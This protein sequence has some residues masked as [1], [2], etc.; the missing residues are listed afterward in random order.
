M[1]NFMERFLKVQVDKVC[2]NP[3]LSTGIDLMHCSQKIRDT[4]C[5]G[6]SRVGAG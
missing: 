5:R 2:Y 6:Q 4:T 3:I 1:W